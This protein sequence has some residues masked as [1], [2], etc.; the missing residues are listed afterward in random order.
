MVHLLIYIY[1]R[2][3]STPIYQTLLKFPLKNPLALIFIVVDGIVCYKVACFKFLMSTVGFLFLTNFLVEVL[4]WN[5]WWPHGV[6]HHK[7]SFGFFRMWSDDGN[8]FP[9]PKGCYFGPA[10]G[11]QVFSKNLNSPKNRRVGDEI[12]GVLPYTSKTKQ[13]KKNG[14]RS[15]PPPPCRCLREMN[16]GVGN[17]PPLN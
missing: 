2:Y 3:H 9:L 16:D 8:G 17:Y 1:H 15:Q 6:F 12:I 13:V 5:C 10:Q 4:G 7:K 14:E 11:V